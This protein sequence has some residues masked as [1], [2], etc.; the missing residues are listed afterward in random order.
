[1]TNVDRHDCSQDCVIDID[2]VIDS[3]VATVRFLMRAI[4]GPTDF[5]LFYVADGGSGIRSQTSGNRQRGK[6]KISLD[7][8]EVPIGI[9][10]T[11]GPSASIASPPDKPQPA[12]LNEI[13]PLAGLTKGF[14]RI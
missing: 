8:R 2:C 6:R 9:E 14:H 1:M 10:F 7:K 12:R 13:R 3:V 5:V 11:V 4:A